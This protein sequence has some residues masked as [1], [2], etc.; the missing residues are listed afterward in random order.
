MDFID[1]RIAAAI[2]G[3]N[4]RCAVGCVLRFCIDQG[5]AHDAAQ[6]GTVGVDG[7]DLRNAVERKDDGQLLPIGRPCRRAVVGLE[8]SQRNTLS[9]GQSLYIKDRTA[10]HETYKKGRGAGK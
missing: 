4:K 7:I 9:Y 3:E 10:G 5:R 6:T 2:A 1:V 8:I